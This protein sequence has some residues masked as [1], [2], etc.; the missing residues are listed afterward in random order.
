MGHETSAGTDPSADSGHGRK[1][2]LWIVHGDGRH[3]GPTEVAAPDERLA[4]SR[5]IGI[6]AQHVVAMFGATFLVPLMA[7]FPPTTT[8]FFS[9]VGTLVSSWPPRAA[10]SASACP[11]TRAAAPKSPSSSHSSPHPQPATSPARTPSSAAEPDSAHESPCPPREVT[12]PP[13]F[14]RGF[15]ARRSTSTG[16]GRGDAPFI[17]GMAGSSPRCPGC[18]GKLP[19]GS[20]QAA[21]SRPPTRRRTRHPE[22]MRADPDL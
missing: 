9:G 3:V 8:I 6:G 22:S 5:T 18:P 13:V 20:Q 19:T 17:T 12:R 2:L 4:W 11:A 21:A 10:G 1:R 7:G 15:R 14:E 16:R